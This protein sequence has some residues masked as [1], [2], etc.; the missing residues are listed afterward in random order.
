MSPR[1]S[2]GVRGIRLCRAPRALELRLDL[3]GELGE[4]LQHLDR[5]IGVVRRLEPRAR[6][7]E[8]RKQLFRLAQRFIRAHAA[9]SLTRSRSATQT[10]ARA[11][12]AR[13]DVRADKRRLTPPP[14]VGC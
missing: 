8:P 2:S 3:A 1:S 6:S 14:P 13:R 11:E 5:L 12:P 7:L 9:P 4:L 10:D